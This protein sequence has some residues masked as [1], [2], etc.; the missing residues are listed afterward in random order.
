MYDGIL[1]MHDGI[2]CIHDGKLCM[3]DGIL[4]IH[5]GKLCMHDGILCIH[6]GKLCMHDGILCIHDGKLCM[7][8]GMLDAI[9]MLEVLCTCIK[10]DT[11]HPPYISGPTKPTLHARMIRIQVHGWIMGINLPLKYRFN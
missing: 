1:C 7:H 9:D 3:Q 6:D 8:D 10:F 2:L 4:C 11:I 5:D